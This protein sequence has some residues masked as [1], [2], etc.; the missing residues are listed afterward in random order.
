MLHILHNF[1]MIQAR[2]LCSH[3]LEKRHYNLQIMRRNSFI[4]SLILLSVTSFGAFAQTGRP[5]AAQKYIDL[6]LK[7][8][9]F[10][11]GLHAF[12]CVAT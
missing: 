8:E 11:S 9:P 4:I 1:A 2:P 5:A 10:R 12:F 6:K 7:E 3:L